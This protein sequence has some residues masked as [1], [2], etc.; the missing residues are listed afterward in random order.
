MLVG[1][2]RVS[3]ADQSLDHYIDMLTADGV[4]ERNIY[5]EKVTGKHRD[6]P[7]LNKMLAELKPND[8]VVI[9]ALTRLGRS[10]SDLYAI[11]RQIEEKGAV[12]KS[13]GESWLDST[14]GKTTTNG[15][16]RNLLFAIFAGLAE[17]EGALI[18]ERTKQGLEAAKARGRSGG[19]PSKRTEKAESVQ[20]LYNS[21]MKIVDIVKQTEL[22]RATVNRIIK[23]M[24]N[25]EPE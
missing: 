9:P 13:L 15:A 7:E 12:I 20:L 17:F 19:R 22:S 4:D 18:S 3:T 2:A 21:G 5:K 10:V 11:V 16:T 23:D 1:Y 6:R 24:K 8:T 25:S 14:A